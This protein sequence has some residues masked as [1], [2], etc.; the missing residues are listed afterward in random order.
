MFQYKLICIEFKF[1][2]IIFSIRFINEAHLRGLSVLIDW[3]PNHLSR[4][5]ILPSCYFPPQNS[6][7]RT[8]RYGPR[9]DYSNL[10]VRRYII[11]SL[12]TYLFNFHFDGVRVDSVLTMRQAAGQE[13]VKKE[14]AD[15]WSLLQEVIEECRKEGGNKIFIAEDLQNDGR[16]NRVMGFDAQWD[17]GFFSI[18]LNVVKAADDKH[19]NLYMIIKILAS[20]FDSSGF[21]RVIYTE[22]HDTV[23]SN[24]EGRMPMALNR[25]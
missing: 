4:K 11:D 7:F 1:F 13:G 17:P 9:P 22:N 12:K 14:I 8:T 15:A 25:K 19:R 24:R 6:P 3:V 10:E 18:M 20:R 16:I 5:A 23:P 2:S 21:G